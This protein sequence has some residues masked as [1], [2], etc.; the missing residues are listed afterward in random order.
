[1]DDTNTQQIVD[2]QLR[3]LQSALG[4]QQVLLDQQYEDQL[5]SFADYYQQ[6]GKIEKQALDAELKHK[7][8]VLNTADDQQKKLIQQEIALLREKRQFIGQNTQRNI[9]QAQTALNDNVQQ[10]QTRLLKAQGNTGKAQTVQFE[11]E[12]NKLIQNLALNGEQAG[13]DI[14]KKLFTIETGKAQLKQLLNGH[15]PMRGA[16]TWPDGS[17][18]RLSFRP[19]KIDRFNYSLPATG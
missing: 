12:F 6:R 18:T 15:H 14:A 1:M 5:V 4:Q 8:T 7:L 10:L 17:S 3:I 11:A 2:Q 9:T 13:I 19:I 16:E